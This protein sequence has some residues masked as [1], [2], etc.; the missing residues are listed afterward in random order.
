MLQRRSRLFKQREVYYRIGN[1]GYQIWPLEEQNFSGSRQ[2]PLRRRQRN[3][4]RETT[5][6]EHGDIYRI[7]SI[8]I[9]PKSDFHSALSVSNSA[10]ILLRNQ[11][12]DVTEPYS[13]NQH[14]GSSL[15]QISNHCRNRTIAGREVNIFH[16]FKSTIRAPA[17]M[18]F[19]T[20]PPLCVTIRSTSIP[21]RI[22]WRIISRATR[23]DPPPAAFQI[24]YKIRNRSGFTHRLRHV[25]DLEGFRVRAER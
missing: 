19:Q 10:K 7:S 1:I 23:S 3:S 15:F 16:D 9:A 12:H 14:H 13:R 20:S 24:R 18:E 17:G 6:S 4:L 11:G 2:H 22:G 8:C 5:I 21:R 25:S